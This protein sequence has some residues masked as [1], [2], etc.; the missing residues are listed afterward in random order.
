MKTIFDFLTCLFLLGLK[1]AL[2]L[3]LSMMALGA[4]GLALKVLWIVFYPLYFLT[5]KPVVW[6]LIK[7]FQSRCPKCKG[8]WKRQFVKTD[9]TEQY[10]TLETVQRIDQGTIYANR[11][12]TPN[13]GF[14]ISRLEQVKM[15]N[16]TTCHFWECKNPACGH[17][18]TTEEYSEYEGSLE[19]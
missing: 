11:L 9:I 8:F 16:E 3:F 18:W 15:V 12:F 6:F 7:A 1:I 19:N 13:E 10:A 2:L 5:L 17:K 14:E 4:V